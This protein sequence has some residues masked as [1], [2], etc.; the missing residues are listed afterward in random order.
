VKSLISKVVD[1]CEYY[2]FVIMIMDWF[3]LVSEIQCPKV[4][5]MKTETE[6]QLTPRLKPNFQSTL[7]HK[8]LRTR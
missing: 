8:P 6:F 3:S 1:L 5:H 7:T 2:K 4:R